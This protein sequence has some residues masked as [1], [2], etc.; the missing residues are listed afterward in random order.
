MEASAVL[1]EQLIKAAIT[2][3]LEEVATVT[4]KLWAP[5]T[6]R[7]IMIIGEG[8]FHSLYAR[9]LRLTNA[10]FP[11][12]AATD[13]PQQTISQ[14]TDLK[15]SLQGRDLTEASEASITLLITFTDMLAVLIGEQ[16]TSNILRSSWG[17]DASHIAGKEVR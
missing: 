14:F 13:S 7:L 5:L 6:S 12:L 1:R 4:D 11:W 2:Q 17:D 9:S 16:L 3:R 10:R 8:G 15:I